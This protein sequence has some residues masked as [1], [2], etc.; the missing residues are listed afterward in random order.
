M[1]DVSSIGEADFREARAGRGKR[2]LEIWCISEL[3]KLFKGKDQATQ[4]TA[5]NF[6]SLGWT[7]T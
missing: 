5:T 6:V 7:W 1:T 4:Q 2:G 3:Q